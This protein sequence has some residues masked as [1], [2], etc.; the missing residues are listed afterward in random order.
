MKT[1]LFA[2]LLVCSTL[3]SMAQS[4]ANSRMVGINATSFVK[5]FL[6]FNDQTPAGTPFQFTY[7]HIGDNGKAF[8]SKLGLNYS[9]STS[10][11]AGEDDKSTLTFLNI[12]LG[13]GYEKRFQLEKR[14]LIYTGIDGL[15][16][17]EQTILKNTSGNDESTDQE[18]EVLGGVSPVLGIQFNIT[19]RLSLSTE[20]GIPIVY[21]MNTQKFSGEFSDAKIT[22]NSFQLTPSLPTFLYLNLTF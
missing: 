12:Q 11:E 21:K 20:A 8:R 10:E 16:G 18:Q 9:N 2:L 6:S 22:T 13:L 3:S 1:S 4:E 15:F 5:S 7:R 17:I 14:W 19:E